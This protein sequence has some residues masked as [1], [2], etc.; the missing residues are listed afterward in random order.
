MRDGCSF[1]VQGVDEKLCDHFSE[2]RKEIEEK[3]KELGLSGGKASAKLTLT[4]RSTKNKIS[5]PELM[6]EWRAIGKEHGWSTPELYEI[7]GKSEAQP[8]F[9]RENQATLAAIEGVEELMKDRSYFREMDALKLTC[10]HSQGRGVSADEAL[11]ATQAVLEQDDIVQLTEINGEKFFTT[12]EH[13]ELEQEMIRNVQE[14]KEGARLNISEEAREKAY[15]AAE[16]AGTPLTE[17]QQKAAEH[18]LDG[19]GKISTIIGDAGT[20]KTTL[21]KPVAETLKES[22]YDVRGIALAAVAAKGMEEGSGIQSGT[23]ASFLYTQKM[24]S[25][26]WNEERAKADFENWVE[27]KRATLPE[28]ER[29]KFN[30]KWT[31]KRADDSR[32]SF[33][34][35]KD[36]HSISGNSVIVLDE[37]GMVNTHQLAEI[38]ERVKESGAKLVAIGDPKQLQ[39]ITQG[40]GFAAISNDVQGARLTEIFRQRDEAEKTAVKQ[41]SEGNVR[42]ALEHYKNEDRLTLAENR[43]EAKETLVS[44]WAKQG[45]MRPAENLILAGTRA[46]VADLNAQAQE[47]R[48]EIGFLRGEAMQKDGV[49]FFVGDRVVFKENQK[50]LGVE[51]GT[52]GTFKGYNSALKTVSIEVDGNGTLDE[53]T[54]RF[55]LKE[56]SK[57]H[58]GYAITT[59]SAQGK[60]VGNAFVLTDERMTDKQL[61]YVQLSRVKDKGHLYSTKEEAGEYLNDLVRNMERDRQKEMALE[62]QRKQQEQQKQAIL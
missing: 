4:T 11:K 58:L 33:E 60:T 20:G 26:G 6:K 44:D 57:F 47:R 10:W 59:H 30:P 8:D 52:F 61:S 21:L 19:A 31:E 49:D 50:K 51:N 46:D 28:D 40:G 53:R 41:I 48:K 38:V 54:R 29:V 9:I 37:A 39:A 27:E 17:E 45:V 24:I 16:E 25:E 12:K 1:A 23:I 15:Q 3:L 36:K 14:L 35:F 7:L 13:L 22:G 18:I 56:Y 62:L 43:D 55:S 42:K 2:R 34:K 5:R 32:E